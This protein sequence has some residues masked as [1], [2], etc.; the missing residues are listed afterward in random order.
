MALG[1]GAIFGVALWLEAGRAA[2]LIAAIERAHADGR[3]VRR[4]LILLPLSGIAASVA[5]NLYGDRVGWALAVPLLLL[6]P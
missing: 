5:M 6:L 2:G 1:F 4:W 3:Q